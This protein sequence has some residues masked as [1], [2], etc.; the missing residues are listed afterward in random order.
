MIKRICVLFILGEKATLELVMIQH[1]N[2]NRRYNVYCPV[3]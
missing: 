2:G 3:Y 1:N